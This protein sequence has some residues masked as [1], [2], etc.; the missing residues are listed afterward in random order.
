MIGRQAIA[1]EFC[2]NT[3]VAVS[4]P[5]ECDLLNLIARYYNVGPDYFHTM[6][7]PLLDGREFTERDITGAPAVAIINQ[8]MARRFFPDTEPIAKKILL[9]R[10]KDALEIVGVVGDV[11]RFEI[12]DVIEPE[13]YYPYMQRPRGASYFA[14]RATS[15]PTSI[16][17]AVRSRIAAVD[18]DVLVT[19]IATVNQMI[20]SAVREPRFHTALIVSFAA[21]A[22]LLS[23]AGLYAVISYSV[24]PTNT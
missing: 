3:P 1:P 2:R 23:A 21:I 19:N 8:T 14:I 18:K 22:L 5:F 6:Q 24:T 20:G 9:V 7:I 10:Q 13:I 12:G 15:D 17:S 16:V 11:R 4:R